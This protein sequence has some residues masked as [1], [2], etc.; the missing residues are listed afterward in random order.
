[1]MQEIT[2][3]I[4][5]VTVK[6]KE[7]NNMEWNNINS[8]LKKQAENIREEAKAEKNEAQ[9]LY[10]SMNKWMEEQRSSAER[11]QHELDKIK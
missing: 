7:Q 9:K 4:P 6:E 8:R 10:E 2:D 11:T 1:M 5:K 3:V